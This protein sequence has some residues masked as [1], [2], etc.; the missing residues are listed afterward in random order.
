M[1][2][3]SRDKEGK[4]DSIHKEENNGASEHIPPH[5]PDIVS[6]LDMDEGFEPPKRNAA[7]S[8]QTI[9]ELLKSDSDIARITEDL[10]SLLISKN[11]IMFTELP[12]PVQ[13]KLL[14]REK[15]RSMLPESR[16]SIIDDDD[17]L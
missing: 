15:L 3:I 10:I 14:T 5:H 4:I 6:F 12:E 8:E 1:P 17:I 9:T 13:R 2:Y 16:H 7:D 11:V